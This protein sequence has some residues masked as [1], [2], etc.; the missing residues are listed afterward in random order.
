[1]TVNKLQRFAEVASFDHVIEYTD[2][3]KSGKPKPAGRWHSEIFGNDHP[4]TLELACGTGAYTVELARRNPKRNYVGLDIKG[5]RLWKGAKIA[6][7]EKLENVRFVR[8]FIDHLDEYFAPDEVDEIWITFA[9][10]YSRAGD[11]NNRLSHP[12]F[13]KLYKSILKKGQLVHFKTDDRAFFQY[14]QRSVQRFGG[15]IVKSVDDIYETHGDDQRLTIQ[16]HF[17]KKHLKKGRSISYC[18]FRFTE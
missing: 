12:K 8:M 18:S 3:Q 2:F 16:T 11:R 9:D 15:S 6:K 4:I 10:P 17:E 13:L 1:M 5:S 14:T 7:Q